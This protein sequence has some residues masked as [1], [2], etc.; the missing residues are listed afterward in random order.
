MNRTRPSFELSADTRFLYQ[1]LAEAAIG[2]MVPYAEL[3]RLIDR[4]VQADARH[5][6]ASA[7]HVAERDGMAFGSIRGQGVKRLTPGEQVKQVDAGLERSRRAARR[8]LNR[9]SIVDFSK[10]TNAEKLH[11]T[12]T[13]GAASAIARLTKPRQIVKLEQAVAAND[14]NRLPVGRVL[15]IIR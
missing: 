4:N 2:D 14:G 1:R 11:L 12:A 10:L 3:S 15:E 6:L 8:A 5:V 9:A 7:L 13:I